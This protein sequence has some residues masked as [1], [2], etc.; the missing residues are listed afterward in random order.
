MQ[1]FVEWTIAE[2][3]YEWFKQYGVVNHFISL[4]GRYCR[5]GILFEE[6]RNEIR[7]YLDAWIAR[8]HE[9]RT[10]LPFFIQ[11]DDEWYGSMSVLEI[12]RVFE[13]QIDWC[14]EF[15]SNS[16]GYL[17]SELERFQTFESIV[18]TAW[19]QLIAR[20]MDEACQMRDAT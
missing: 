12:R 4:A 3:M 2:T 10:R 5:A 14:I 11:N 15:F 9:L 18:K 19:N 7:A 6:R 16:K 8:F 13:Y 20:P 1:T 17:E